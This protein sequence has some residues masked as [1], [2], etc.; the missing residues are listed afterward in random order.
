[1]VISQVFFGILTDPFVLCSPSASR[2]VHR[3]RQLDAKVFLSQIAL[4]NVIVSGKAGSVPWQGKRASQ[5]HVQ[6]LSLSPGPHLNWAF[7]PC[8]FDS[9]DRNV[10]RVMTRTRGNGF[11]LRAGL[12]GI[13]GRNS[14]L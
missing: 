4:G 3:F 1:M 2:M 14:W 13:M 6:P 11:E 8:S 7:F 10:G 5:S 12:D 9:M